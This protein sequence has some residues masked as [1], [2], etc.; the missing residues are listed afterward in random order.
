LVSH[1][2]NFFSEYFSVRDANKHGKVLA[3]EFD[4][5][6]YKK[7]NKKIIFSNKFE[8]LVDKFLDFR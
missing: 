4:T 6:M 3:D 1:N 8:L 2:F 5:E 7:K